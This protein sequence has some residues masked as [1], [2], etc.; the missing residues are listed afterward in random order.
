MRVVCICAVF[1]VAAAAAD[2]EQAKPTELDRAIAIFQ[3][4]SRELGLRDGAASD[5]AEIRA[6]SPGRKKNRWHGRLFE[7]FRNDFLDAVPH[8]VAQRG[9]SKNILRRNQYGANVTGPVVIPKLYDG[10]R[11]T[12]FTFTYEGVREKVGRSALNTIPTL[13]ER[14]GDWS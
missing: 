7:N 6:S 12:F 5:G 4:R 11:V 14:G 9:G 2:P 1:T 13:A 10:D 3:Q 8:D